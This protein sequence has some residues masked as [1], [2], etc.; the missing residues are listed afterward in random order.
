MFP[1]QVQVY[2]LTITMPRPIMLAA[3]AANNRPL[4]S[5]GKTER[6]DL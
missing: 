1:L 3:R 4:Q 6:W 5:P 2:L